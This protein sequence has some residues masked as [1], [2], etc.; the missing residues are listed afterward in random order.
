MG[1]FVFAL[2]DFLVLR[3]E[4]CLRRKLVTTNTD[5]DKI[6]SLQ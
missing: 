5:V 6:V 2:E 1:Y 3:P 4:L